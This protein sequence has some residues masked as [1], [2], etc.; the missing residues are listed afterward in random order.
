MRRKKHHK[1]PSGKAFEDNLFI[2]QLTIQFL[3][4]DSQ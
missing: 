1:K 3:V 2:Y 4:Q